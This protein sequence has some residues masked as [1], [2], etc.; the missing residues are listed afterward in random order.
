MPFRND[1]RASIRMLTIRDSVSSL[2]IDDPA[3]MFPNDGSCWLVRLDHAITMIFVY[4]IAV[5]LVGN[6]HDA[7]HFASDLSERSLSGA[8]S[9]GIEMK[10]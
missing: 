5:V 7:W 8:Y 9:V 10:L 6:P 1:F 4:S 3:A 2:S